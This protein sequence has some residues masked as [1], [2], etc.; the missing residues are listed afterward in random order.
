MPHSSG[1]S[2]EYRMS[3]VKLVDPVDFVRKNSDRFFIYSDPRVRADEI[4]TRICLEAMLCGSRSMRVERFGA[5]R[6]IS[7]GDHDWFD[8]LDA[9]A[10]FS[11]M[12]PF[13]Q[14]GVN[15]SR[16]EVLVSALASEYSTSRCGVVEHGRISSRSSEEIEAVMTDTAFKRILAFR[17]A[18]LDPLASA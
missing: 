1:P 17:M 9:T 14:A 12:V 16:G 2:G 5:W 13:P 4:A 15:A 11:S 8:D 18:D 7:S 3:D 6:V 10:L